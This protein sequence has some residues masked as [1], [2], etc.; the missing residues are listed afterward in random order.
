[1]S[2]PFNCHLENIAKELASPKLWYETQDFKS[3]KD[4]VVNNL[5]MCS[6]SFDDLFSR[7]IPFGIPAHHT[8]LH[9]SDDRYD[10]MLELSLPS[11]RKISSFVN[12]DN[13]VCLDVSD[14]PYD[15]P[16]A[17]EKGLVNRHLLKNWLDD[18][19]LKTFARYKNRF[20]GIKGGY[21]KLTYVLHDISHVV[22]AQSK[23]RVSKIVFVPSILLVHE[24]FSYS[25]LTKLTYSMAKYSFLPCTPDVETSR[26]QVNVVRNALII[27]QALCEA[28]GL[29]EIRY[30]HLM[31]LA[32][33][34]HEYAISTTLDDAFLLL[35]YGL[36]DA[37][38][39]Q[40]LSHYI[41]RKLNLLSNIRCEKL[42]E[43]AIILDR[44]YSTLSSYEDQGM[45]SYKRCESHFLI[46]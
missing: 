14:V 29:T 42:S 22:F 13:Y 11:Y 17:D 8:R 21:Y 39:R 19:F 36:C 9:N 46:S 1:M 33:N 32:L 26:C 2:E 12:N 16:M 24:G 30:Y 28:K 38:K 4:Y 6:K 18:I 10:V 41:V 37:V 3:V 43:Y 35:L 5:C 15:L 23:S 25:A 27:L 45:L 7:T 44:A 34:L 20:R 31:N 40:H